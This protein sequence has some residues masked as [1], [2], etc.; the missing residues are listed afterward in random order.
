MSMPKKTPVQL[1][2]EI[3]ETLARGT[4]SS[5]SKK[6]HLD[7]YS[8]RARIVS[9][10]D[11]EDVWDGHFEI[12]A[13]DLKAARKRAVELLHD[14]PYYDVRFDPTVVLDDVEHIGEVELLNSETPEQAKAALFRA[15]LE[16]IS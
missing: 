11:G 10:F 3:A 7:I 4:P 2:R 9:G 1:D 16:S 13:D 6:R 15:A 5:G 8:V 12:P 14:S